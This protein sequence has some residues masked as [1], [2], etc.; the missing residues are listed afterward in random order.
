MSIVRIACLVVTGLLCRVVVAESPAWVMR[1]DRQTGPHDGAMAVY[2]E[3][4]NRFLLV[5]PAQREWEGAEPVRGFVQAFDPA[6]NSWSAFAGPA[7][8]KPDVH[9]YYQVALDPMR[10]VLYCLSGGSVLDELA[11]DTQ[12]WTRHPP[13]KEL[14][15]LSWHALAL[16]PQHRQ[17]VVIGSDKR[18]PAIGWIRTVVRNLDSG[19]WTTLSA[20]TPEQWAVHG[21]LETAHDAIARLVGRVRL[22]WYRDPQGTGTAEQRAELLA[23][24]RALAA[25]PSLSTYGNTLKTVEQQISSQNLLAALRTAKD[26]MR[27]V[28][29]QDETGFPIPR[30]RRNSPLVFDPSTGQFVLFGGDHE[31][32]QMNDT[33]VLNLRG[34]AWRRLTPDINPSPRAGHALIALPRA[35]RIALYEGY[36]GSSNTDYGARPMQPINPIQLWTLDVAQQR[37]SLHHT[38]A[39]PSEKERRS[40]ISVGPGVQGHF[41]GYASEWYSP[42]AIAADSRDRLLLVAPARRD[43]TPSATWTLEADFAVADEPAREKW[44]VAPNQR[45]MRAL[46]FRTEFCEVDDPAVA[47]DLE[48]LPA[49]QWVALPPSNR[50]PCRGCRQRDWGTSVWDSDRDQ[51]L[52]WGGG[53]CVR[54]AS[55][56][57]HYSPASGRIVEGI[58]ADEPYGANGGG[59]FDSSLLNR[60]WVSTHNYKHYAYDP[61][62]RM[63]V[64]GRGYLYAPDRMDWLRQEPLPIPYRFEWGSTVLATTPHGVVA[65]ARRGDEES[66]G[67]WKFDR[68]QGWIELRLHG[69]LFVPWCDSHGMVYDSARDR[70][71]ISSVGGKYGMISDGT[72]LSISLATGQ[73]SPVIPQNPELGRT[74]CARELAYVAH[75]DWLLIGD[76]EETDDKKRPLTRIYD[77]RANRYLLL[78]AGQAPDGYGTG[79]MYDARRKLV[80]SF[81]TNGDAWA[82]RL[83]PATAVP[84]TAPSGKPE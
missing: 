76:H 20:A 39:I 78:D 61:R 74:H 23:E 82:I 60:P 29:L 9:P 33:W 79:W 19:Q 53:H 28:E 46:P 32:Y 68:V 1:N 47:P 11:L 22:D 27:L 59:G 51:I 48:H 81:T 21:Q 58:D 43:K 67:L 44:G 14:E 10:K 62:C 72:L 69:K 77:C 75:A 42:P 38:W 65:W 35:G 83:D 15:G 4:L 36:V 37:W 3:S 17:L 52:L 16:D 84:A 30:S 56:V 5:G 71:L 7:V 31:D 40:Q 49:N 6:L 45:H 12:V 26:L 55:A 70:L 73:L 63:L 80:Y 34:R 57:V 41:D 25:L 50:N 24:C 54:S 13:A 66:A 2:A 18:P 8:A 64:S